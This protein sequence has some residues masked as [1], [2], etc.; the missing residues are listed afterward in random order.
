MTV[1]QEYVDA[2]STSTGGTAK[3]KYRLAKAQA[4]VMG[5]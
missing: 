2:I 4:L 1:D 5:E 3:V